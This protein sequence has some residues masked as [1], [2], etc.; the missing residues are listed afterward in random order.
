MC[1]NLS[2]LMTLIGCISAPDRVDNKCIW[3][4]NVP[5]LNVMLGNL[6]VLSLLI[7]VFLPEKQHIYF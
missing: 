1:L 3:L 6:G 7:V 5:C 4:D 2:W